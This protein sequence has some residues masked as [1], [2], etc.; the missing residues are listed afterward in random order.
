MS[1]CSICSDRSSKSRARGGSSE[2]KNV[3]THRNIP[4]VRMGFQAGVEVTDLFFE[5]LC[6]F[7]LASALAPLR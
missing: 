4:A 3:Q 2:S 7:L 5:F 1:W 6:C